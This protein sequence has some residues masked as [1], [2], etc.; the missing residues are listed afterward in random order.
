MKTRNVAVGALAAVLV[1]ALWWMFFLKPTR[2]QTSKVHK[3][4]AEAERDALSLKAQLAQVSDKARNKQLEAQL[5][6]L[7]A[8]VPTSPELA[9]FVRTANTIA[10]QSGV[11]WVSVTPG[12][13]T[14]TAGV[15]AISLGIMVKG[16]YP[17]VLDYLNRLQNLDRLVVV[18]SINVSASSADGST[19]GELPG[20]ISATG[21]QGT[22]GLQITGR[23]FVGSAVSTT[24][25]GAA[26]TGAP[27]AGANGSTPTGNGTTNNGPSGI[28]AGTTDS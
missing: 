15:N 12:Q 9:T 6:R 7:H 25:A 13:P 18:D 16:T 22:L 10:D 2:S 5:T 19:G 8:A 23:M 26:T 24:P 1:L 3:E 27:G 28:P 21:G 4:V 11:A 14:V 20:Y 17:Q